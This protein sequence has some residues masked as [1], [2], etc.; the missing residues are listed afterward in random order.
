MLKGFLFFKVCPMLNAT[1][2]KKILQNFVPDELCPDRVPSGV[3]E[4][5][6]SEVR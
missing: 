2:I 4:A 3:F 6:D 5:L 1:L